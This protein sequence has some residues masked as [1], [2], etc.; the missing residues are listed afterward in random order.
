MTYDRYWTRQFSPPEKR[1]DNL[2]LEQ[3]MKNIKIHYYT[4][5]EPFFFF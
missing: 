4:M 2:E 5:L 3:K 1:K